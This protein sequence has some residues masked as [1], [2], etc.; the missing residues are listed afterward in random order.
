M[1]KIWGIFYANMSTNVK[2]NIVQ[3]TDGNGNSNLK[4]MQKKLEAKA[5]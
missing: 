4:K 3:A 1:R 2:G 5:V